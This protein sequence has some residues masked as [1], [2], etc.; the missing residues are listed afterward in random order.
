[1]MSSFL[2]KT[3]L[4]Q[5][6]PFNNPPATTLHFLQN[7]SHYPLSTNNTAFQFT[8]R[9]RQPQNKNILPTAVQ[10]PSP[11]LTTPYNRPVPIQTS[12]SQLINPNTNPVPSV[13]NYTVRR[14]IPTTSAAQFTTPARVDNVSKHM[15]FT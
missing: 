5:A 7:P 3:F 4:L 9:G 15:F 10:N 13:P 14:T 11:N 12:T 6:L 2:T 8:L 1:M